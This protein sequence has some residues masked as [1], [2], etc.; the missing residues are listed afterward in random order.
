MWSLRAAARCGAGQHST[1]KWKTILQKSNTFFLVDFNF[2]NCSNRA[3][4]RNKSCPGTQKS[5]RLVLNH[6]LERKSRYVSL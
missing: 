4:G 2:S 3:L 1:E 5:I 6:A